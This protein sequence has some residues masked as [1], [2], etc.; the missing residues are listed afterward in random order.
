LEPKPF[1]TLLLCAVSSVSVEY[2]TL[3]VCTQLH[4]TLPE[5]FLTILAALVV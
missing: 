5:L 3:Q 4:Q 2:E 1:W